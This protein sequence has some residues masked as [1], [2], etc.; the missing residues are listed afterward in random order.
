MDVSFTQSASR[1]VLIA[2]ILTPVLSHPSSS[3][4]QTADLTNSNVIVAAPQQSQTL[5]QPAGTR[6][7]L[8]TPGDFRGDFSQPILF[9]QQGITTAQIHAMQGATAAH[10][11][12]GSLADV[13]TCGQLIPAGAATGQ[14]NCYSAFQRALSPINPVG[15]Y[16]REEPAIDGITEWGS[17]L[18]LSDRDDVTGVVRK[19]TTEFAQELDVNVASPTTAGAALLF[20]AI[21]EQQPANLGAIHLPLP[22][23]YSGN[24]WSYGFIIDDGA[25]N[26]PALRL[27]TAAPSPNQSSLF[28]R[29]SSGSQTFEMMWRDGAAHNRAS[30]VRVDA[31]GTYHLASDRGVEVDRGGLTIDDGNLVAP[32]LSITRGV[33]ANTGMQHLRMP[34]GCSTAAHTGAVCTSANAVWAASFP[35]TRYTLVCTLEQVRGVPAIS[36]VAKTAKGFT[37]TAVALTDASATG[38]ADCIA[39]HD[40]E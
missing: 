15:F 8:V 39:M 9:L 26:G 25:V 7:F 2:A 29:A 35:D 14:A 32:S 30:S 12:T 6:L 3:A 21:F 37:V 20:G 27:G 38:L 16:S 23:L 22:H 28:G 13:I 18:N 34:L 24:R 36:S 17:N 5:A 11:R 40:P 1:A 4:Q 10:P 33:D 19:M 31:A